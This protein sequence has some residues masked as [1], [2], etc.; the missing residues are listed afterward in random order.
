MENTA[1]QKR[2]TTPTVI[3]GLQDATDITCLLEGSGFT[4]I[5]YQQ[6]IAQLQLQR[7]AAAGYDEALS[8]QLAHPATSDRSKTHI[9]AIPLLRKFQGI[10]IVMG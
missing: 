8:P 2:A 5:V 10:A 3:R 9:S 6:D 4:K 1:A 7:I